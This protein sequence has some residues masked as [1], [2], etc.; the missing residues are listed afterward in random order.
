M[1][2][3]CHMGNARGA[4][5]FAETDRVGK[6]LPRGRHYGIHINYASPLTDK[7]TWPCCEAFSVSRE[8]LYRE[9]ER[10]LLKYHPCERRKKRTSFFLFCE[11]HFREN[12]SKNV[13]NRLS[14]DPLFLLFH[15]SKHE[16]KKNDFSRGW[17]K[18]WQNLRRTESWKVDA[19]W[20]RSGGTQWFRMS[21]C[22]T[23]Y[24]R[25]KINKFGYF[26]EQLADTL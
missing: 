21:L 18:G 2:R 16:K 11:S 15:F 9:R 1:G 24:G 12:R 17:K 23:I 26:K 13:I 8:L 5:C 7:Q 25:S 3:G 14:F 20:E 4:R 22:Q 10:F 6:H 19:N